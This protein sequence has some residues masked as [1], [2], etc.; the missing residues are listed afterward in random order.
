MNDPRILH[1]D[2]R[3]QLATLADNSIDTIITD[4][5]Y[6]LAFMGKKWDASGVAFDVATWEQCLRVMKP[7]GHLLAFGGTRTYHRM[8]C[9]IEDAGFEIRDSIHW[10][11]GS[12]FPKSLD[13][14]KAIDKAAGAEREMRINERWAERYPNGPGGNLSGNGRSAHYGQAKRV[15]DGPLLTSA[16]ATDAARTWAGWGTALKPA[17]EPIVLA[18]KP[19]NG[20]VAANVLEHGVGALNIDATRIGNTGGTTKGDPPKG[21]SN[22]VWNNGLNGACEIVPIAAGRWPANLT[23]THHHEC[24]PRRV[25]ADTYGEDEHGVSG[26]A[27]GYTPGHNTRNTT[28]VTVWDCHPECPARILDTQSGHLHGSG[29][30]SDQGSGK[31]ND[32]NAS[33]YKVS[34]KGQAA[35]DHGDSGGASRFFTQTA[36]D[37]AGDV[38]SFHYVAKPSKRERNAGLDHLDDQHWR[39]NYGDGI[40]DGRPHTSPDYKYESTTKNTHPT[41]KPV[42]LLRHLARLTTPRGGV[43]LDPFLGSGTTA[44]AATLEQCNWIG[45]ELTADYIPIIQGRVAWA[46]TQHDTATPLI[47]HGNV[48]SST[49]DP[50]L[51]DGN[52]A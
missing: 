22:G 30:K 6:E 36:W 17:H 23:L 13:V 16:P 46:E 26:F 20:T 19:L 10:V 24:I 35:R 50:T 42:A 28:T 48:T 45:V 52:P 38:A 27:S 44:V 14:S 5:P 47:P 7:G 41:V 37:H 12:G 2:C 8:T 43:I 3:Q 39:G 25:T 33:S 4:P 18:R 51:F 1:G 21:K 11:Y 32:Y 15:A 40:Q 9:A 29:N 31:G 34:Y 49:A